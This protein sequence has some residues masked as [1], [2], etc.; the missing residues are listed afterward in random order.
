VARPDV[1]L[2]QLRRVHEIDAAGA[3]EADRALDL[4]GDDLVALSLR[5]ARD[6]LLVPHLHLRQV[7]EAALREGAK[8]VERGRGLVVRLDHPRW[9]GGSRLRG[10]LVVVDHVPE[11]DGSS[12]SPTRSTGST[13][14]WRTARRSGRPSRA[15][16]PA[17][18]HHH[19]HLQQNL[20]LLADRDSREVPK[21]LRT[22]ARLEEEGAAG[23]DL[24]ERGLQ[25]TGLAADSGGSER[26]R[27]TEAS[28]AAGSGHSGW[29]NAVCPRQLE[30]VQWRA[31]AIAPV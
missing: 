6:E 26:S 3:H 13:S 5:C 2:V 18:D 16:A 1:D 27:S 28:A 7:G 12:S 8:Q 9:I 17:I 24:A 14:V 29:C 30:G 21:R 15:V 23:G 20:Q 19:R 10:G 22:V 25:L 4:R 31:S 11:E